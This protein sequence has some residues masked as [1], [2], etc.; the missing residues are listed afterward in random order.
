MLPDH[1]KVYISFYFYPW[2]Y[3]M[4]NTYI[5][6]FVSDQ[7]L[8]QYG[9]FQLTKISCLLLQYLEIVDSIICYI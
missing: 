4:E 1:R 5:H 6:Q 2:A 8:Q 9:G 3:I 7:P